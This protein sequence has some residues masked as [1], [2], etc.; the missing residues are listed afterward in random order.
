MPDLATV[1]LSGFAEF[2][3]QL[4]LLPLAVQRRAMIA[5][6]RAG[7]VVFKK[8]AKKNVPVRR[9]GVLGFA[10]KYIGA[11]GR[12]EGIRQ[13]GYLKRSIISRTVSAKKSPRP[14]IQIGPRR[15][16]FY[17]AFFETGRGGPGRM[18]RRRFLSGAFRTAKFRAQ[19]AV[20]DGLWKAIKKEIAKN[21][22]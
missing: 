16:A 14:M 13:P 1:K 10:A 22:R 7:A 17:G 3:K 8:E 11:G 9:A 18:P 19:T 12:R 20:R 5:G 15:T 4:K 6:L 2:D 21:G